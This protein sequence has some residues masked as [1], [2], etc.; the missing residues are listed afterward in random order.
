[1]HNDRQERKMNIINVKVDGIDHTD[2]PDF[3]DAFICYA[4]HEDG[5]PLSDEE[6]EGIDEDLVYE[7]VLEELR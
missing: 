4:E 6:L 3:V 5:T 2:Y 7:Y 1:M